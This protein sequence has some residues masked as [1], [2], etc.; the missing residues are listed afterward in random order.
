MTPATLRRLAL[1]LVDAAAWLVPAGDRDGWRNQW[2][3][4]VWHRIDALDRSGLVNARTSR[5]VLART[6][7]AIWHAAWRRLRSPGGPMLRHDVAHALRTLAA[8]PVFTLVAVV[9]L[10]LGI[11]ANTVI[12]SWIEA[13]LLTPLPGVTAAGSLAAVNVTTRSRQDISLSYPNYIDLRDA[14][15]PAIGGLAV[16]SSG[17]L[18]L[19]VGD[20]A[21]RLWGAIVSGTLFEVLGV[22]AALGRT[23]TPADDLT[24][25]GHPVAVLTHRGWQRRFGGRP[26]IVG[27]TIVLNERAFTV[28]GVTP[29]A[30]HGPQPLIGIDVMI[31][32]AMQSAFVPGNRLAARGSGWLQMLLRL[33]PGAALAD[34][35]A[36]LDVA[37][38]RLAA[39][40]PDV[41]A[42]RGLRAFP[43]WRQPSGGT[44]MVLPVM[45]VL[46]GL[47]A[48]LLALVC[49]NMAGLLLARASGRQ[50]EL[51]VRV[52]LGASRWQVVRLLVAETTVLAIAA[53]IL[54]AIVTAWS[55]Q[56][57]FAFIPPLPI[58]VVVDAGL[59]LRVVIFSS[60]VSLIAGLGLGLVPGLQASRGDLVAPLKDGAASGGTAR[61]S[62][63]RQGLIVAQVAMALVLLVSAGLF[64][65]TLDAARRVD[66]G[67]AART[68]LVG[69]VDVGAAG[70]EPAQGLELYR[71][72]T[73]ALADVPGVE[74]VGIG[75]RLPLTMTD[76][77]DR[78]VS[79]D[80]YTPAPGEE[81]TTYYAS[82]GPGYFEAL[83]LPIVEGRGI[84]ERD[85]ADAPFVVVVNE[86]MAGR[87]WP[88]RSALGGRVTVGDRAAEV[89]GVARDSKYRS[90]GEAPI[91]F[92]Y[93]A[94]DQVYR[95][96]MRVIVRTNGS[97]DA[98]V[99]AARQ[100]VTRVAP[101][102][103]LF[104]V[105]TLAEHLAFG[106]FLL[107]M[108]A[109]LLGVFG[110]TAALLAAL[111]LYGVIAQGVAAQTREIGVRMSLGASRSQVRRMVV[112]QGLTLAA[113]GL[114]VGGALAVVVTRLFQPQ[115][116][117][118]SPYDPVAFLVTVALL[119]GTS[120]AAA[121]L[122]A[123]RASRLD[124]V[125]ALRVD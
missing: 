61:R 11:G 113:I 70:Y 54:A 71:R 85:R 26:D 45:A 79:V 28:I 96:G 73:A 23:L 83:Q 69:M 62:L 41:N 124:P 13:T 125:K 108:A 109:T 76:S 58:P 46:G 50:R 98:I 118:I 22:R 24:P 103:P 91:A 72:I 82:V 80:G 27:R 7:G 78:T 100:A 31:P 3:A 51:A 99:A 38:S 106:Y 120:A 5:A 48:V 30:F 111:G 55:G 90:L 37:A 87:Y 43:L 117:G 17:A 4:D 35:Q 66:L 10:A 49:A 56:L 104:D 8:R 44:G 20:D 14:Q 116:L 59:N 97:P 47:V 53:G 34:A 21:E 67:F 12:F 29:P 36:G 95:P 105:Q 122:P 74:A 75:Q 64:L 89:V 112:G 15:V 52:S 65:R 18:T 114:A 77:S 9:T 40:Y 60:V 92:M 68:G 32:M 101:G 86:T 33:A 57:L 1:G 102:V 2:R 42:G 39:S 6:A 81:M 63:V 107:E 19:R 88:G 110:A 121:L 84:A 123:V 115:L 94:V 119:A 93:L 25:G 16:F